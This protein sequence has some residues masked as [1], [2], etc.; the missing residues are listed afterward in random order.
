MKAVFSPKTEPSTPKIDLN[1]RLND[2]DEISSLQL[3]DIEEEERGE[4]VD[5]YLDSIFE[6]S[7]VQNVNSMK[8]FEEG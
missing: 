5:N 3:D 1:D 4:N 8:L 2:I 6:M 7:S